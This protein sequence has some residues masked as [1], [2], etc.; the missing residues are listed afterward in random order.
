MV[1]WPVSWDLQN[2]AGFHKFCSSG[3]A[4]DNGII[5]WILVE[6]S[7]LESPAVVVCLFGGEVEYSDFR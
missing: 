1:G 7:C 2:C 5:G 6:S 4:A 3:G